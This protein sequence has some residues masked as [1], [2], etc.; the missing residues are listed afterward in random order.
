MALPEDWAAQPIVA[1]PING[2]AIRDGSAAALRRIAAELHVARDAVGRSFLARQFMPYPFHITRPFR[3]SGDPDGMATLYL[4]S[5]SGGVYAGDRLDLSVDM[6]PGA[7]IHLT[8]QAST[9]IHAARGKASAETIITLHLAEG[10][11]CEWLPDP[12]ILLSGARL[13]ARTHI[14]IEPG[15]RLILADSFLSH[16]PWD[17]GGHFDCYASELSVHRA[18]GRAVFAERM[19]LNGSLWPGGPAAMARWRCHGLLLALGT[20]AN[21]AALDAVRARISEEAPAAFAGVSALRDGCGWTA[22]MFAPEAV[23]LRKASL[24][25]W[26]GARLAM[27]GA[28]PPGRRK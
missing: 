2:D 27:A 12:V 28:L 14:H 15:V 13:H 22:R 25:A 20:P 9:I 11:F 21:G 24:A 19:E 5:S 16:A 6:A 23:S 7:A 3:L 4:Q 10:A 18:D 8:T 17:A 26:R 1:T